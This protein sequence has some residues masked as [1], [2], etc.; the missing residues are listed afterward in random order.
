MGLDRMRLGLISTVPGMFKSRDM[1]LCWLFVISGRKP[2][3][4]MAKLTF[5]TQPGKCVWLGRVIWMRALTMRLSRIILTAVGF[6]VLFHLTAMPSAG[7][8][9]APAEHAS[10]PVLDRVGFPKGYRDTYVVLR[11]ENRAKKHQI[12]TSYGNLAAASVESKEQLPYPYGSVFVLETADAVKDPGGQPL[13]D[14]DGFY[15]R[16]PVTGLHVMRR[17]KGFGEAYGGNRTGEWE[18][19]EYKSDGSYITAPKNS[20]A[21]AACHIKAGPERDWIFRGRFPSKE[22]MK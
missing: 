2:V 16:G 7:D 3:C 17:E 4:N 22:A 5:S 8:R 1:T 10:A 9:D 15:Q 11:R 21:C 20:A 19:V 6:A 18:Y 13:L 14:A 12:V